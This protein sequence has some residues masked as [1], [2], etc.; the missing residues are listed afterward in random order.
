MAE[1]IPENPEIEPLTRT[2][3]LV[4]MGVTAIMLLAV[5]K[6]WLLFGSVSLLP[7]KLIAMDLLA[8]CA[9]GL[10]ITTGSAIVYR[11]W[12]GYRRSADVYLEVVLK[13]LFWP[14]LIW[15]GLLPG[16]SEELLFRGVMLSALGMNFTGLILS[17]SCFGI[18]HLGGTDQWP[19]A[20]WATAVGLLLGYSVLAT[21]NLLVPITAHIC[22]NLIS[23]CVWKWENNQVKQ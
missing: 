3:V 20:V 11:L 13:P 2:Q 4:A 5:A 8:G 17:S 22:T 10:A 23:S 15:L 16:L 14:D 7:V 9:I 19:Y 18:L 6:L 21:G 12:P 1:K